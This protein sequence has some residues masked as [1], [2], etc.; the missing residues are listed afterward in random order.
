MAQ[1]AGVKTSNPTLLFKSIRLHQDKID[2]H[3]VLF[4]PD[5]KGFPVVVDERVMRVLDFFSGGATFETMAEAVGTQGV[6]DVELKAIVDALLQLTFLRYREDTVRYEARDLANHA[7]STFS[8]WLHINNH[9][10]SRL[11]LLLRRQVRC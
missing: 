4:A 10:N 7:P 3:W 11:R 8:V 6:E 9:C 1:I 2:Q 5:T